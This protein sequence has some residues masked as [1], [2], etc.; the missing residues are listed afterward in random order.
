M[1]RIFK[2]K[3][4]QAECESLRLEGRTIGLVPTMGALHSGHRQL[5]TMAR[6][7]CDIVA[8]SIFVNE[9]QFDNPVDLEKY[10]R[11]IDKDLEIASSHGVDLLFTPESE[12]MHPRPTLFRIE[13]DRLGDIL[14]GAS[15][16]GHFAGVATVVA[17]LFTLTGRCKAYFG[18]KDFQQLSVISRMVEEMHFAV[19]IVPVPIV[20]DANG[21]ALSSRNLR[22]DSEQLKSA[23]SLSRALFTARDAI[24]GGEK[25]TGKIE[26]LMVHEL[27][28]EIPGIAKSNQPVLDYALV[29]DPLTLVEP[30]RIDGPV[31]LLVAARVGSVRLIDNIG[32]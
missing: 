2:A 29:V 5:I 1:N 31:R 13:V 15:S 30:E 22:L 12:D 24:A 28:H 7:Q 26:E 6:E 8:V 3:E 23:L 25:E 9:L 14:E 17:K 10:P 19:E 18:E 4:F 21:L 20:R 27:R 16:P 32:V 11:A